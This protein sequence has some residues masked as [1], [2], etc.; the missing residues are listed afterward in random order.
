[1]ITPERKVDLRQDPGKEATLQL[2]LR[3]YCDSN[4][5]KQ[6]IAREPEEPYGPPG[7]DAGQ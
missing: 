7:Y 4:D 5:S 2:F 1:L 6:K 3:I